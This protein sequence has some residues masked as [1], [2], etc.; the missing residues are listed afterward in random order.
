MNDSERKLL[1]AWRE[2]AGADG[3]DIYYRVREHKKFLLALRDAK[4]EAWTDGY[5]AAHWDLE[6]DTETPNPYDE[7]EGT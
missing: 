5:L 3:Q 2:A 6:D 4:A 1:T 7:E